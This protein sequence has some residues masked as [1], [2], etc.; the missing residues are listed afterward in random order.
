VTEPEHAPSPF[1]DR[2]W[3]E[4]VSVG[5]R[6]LQALSGHKVS[7]WFFLAV[8]V[9][10]FFSVL[11]VALPS[12]RIRIWPRL[13]LVSH[14]ANIRLTASGAS[15]I[16]ASGSV[17]RSRHSLPLISIRSNLHHTLSFTEISKKF[18]GENA[19][20][21][22]SFINESDEQYSLRAGTRL[23]NQAGMVFR[24]LEPVDIPA[25][26]ALGPGV[27]NAPARA[28]PK[29]LYDQILGERG[30][31]PAGIKW[32]I[33]GLPP[34]E[35]QL[36]YARNNEE[37]KGG[38]T[39]YGTELAE[40]D[41]ELA[42]KQLQQELLQA[43][44]RSTEETVGRM[45]SATGEEHV[46]L[47][48]D[49][50]TAMSFTG[51]SLPQDLIG[52]EVSS[53]PVE[54]H[55]AYAVLAYNKDALLQL[56]LPGLLEHVEAGQELIPG[57][58]VKDG[59]SVHVIEYDDTLQWVKITAEL[60]GKQRAVLRASTVPGREFGERIRDAIRG[61]TVAEAERIIQ[62]F[63]EVERVEVSLWPPWRRFLPSLSSNI[64]LEPQE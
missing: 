62:N 58:T 37:A 11:F 3:R 39:L 23:A 25:L 50:L 60:T 29:D 33:L 31:V 21:E 10:L 27:K 38:V 52:T 28:D 44:K 47:Q 36:V 55:I 57:T 6:R 46:I 9:T 51:V 59:I 13:S 5:Y 14:T 42:E 53:A 15:M 30:N 20:V 41:L 16:D 24:T 17:L 63:P 1:A 18:L 40:S 32:E 2:K 56:L 49:V 7:V 4:W 19:E 64:A 43:A 61:K 34:Q 35:R 26:S 54:G 12:A 8:S 48:Y 22:M 45:R